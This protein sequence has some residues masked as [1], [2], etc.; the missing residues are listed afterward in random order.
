MMKKRKAGLLASALLITAALSGCSKEGASGD[1]VVQ[2]DNL[3]S[4]VC[5]QQSRYYPGDRI[6]FRATVQDS[7]TSKLVEDAKVKLVLGNGT[8]LPM[9]L[10][11]HGEEQTQLWSVGYDVPQDAAT[12]TLDYSIVAESGSKKAEFKP[13]NV[14]LSKVTIV[15]PGTPI[16]G[17][18]AKKALEAA[19]KK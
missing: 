14:S 7:S 5:V 13:F 19:Q 6:V 15:A 2:G 10:G 4:H 17:D 11:K 8:E 9:V 18:E 12:G 3:L 16:G 1:L